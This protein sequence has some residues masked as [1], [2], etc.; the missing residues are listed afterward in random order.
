[1]SNRVPQ[2]DAHYRT[3]D[4]PKDVKCSGGYWVRIYPD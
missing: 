1:M 3:G 2:D 4:K